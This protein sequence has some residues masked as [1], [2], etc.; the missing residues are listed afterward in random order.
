MIGTIGSGM[1]SRQVT[2]GLWPVAHSQV[3]WVMGKNRYWSIRVQARLVWQHQGCL[4]EN[5]ILTMIKMQWPHGFV[6]ARSDTIQIN[7]NYKETCTFWEADYTETFTTL[8]ESD[9]ELNRL[10]W[11]DAYSNDADDYVVPTATKFSCVSNFDGKYIKFVVSEQGKYMAS[12]R[13]P[14]CLIIH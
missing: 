6:I 3:A 14:K 9:S 1:G 5:I 2:H 4:Q 12:S 11:C 7:K 13:S 8:E 10:I